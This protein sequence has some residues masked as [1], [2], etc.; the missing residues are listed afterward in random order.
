[1][2]RKEREALWDQ[3]RDDS[4]GGGDGEGGDDVPYG[5]WSYKAIKQLAMLHLRAG[6]EARARLARATVEKTRRM[7]PKSLVRSVHS[8]TLR[9]RYPCTS[10]IPNKWLWFKT[11]LKYSHLL[12]EMNETAKLQL[13]IK[14][15]L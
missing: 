4:D 15:M 14:D 5:I 6:D 7:D 2:V 11:N 10:L 3:H 9:V 1:V 8:T 13:V 12:C